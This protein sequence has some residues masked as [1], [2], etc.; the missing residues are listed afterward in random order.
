MNF[1]INEERWIRVSRP[2][3]G[4]FAS[5]VFQPDCQSDC[6]FVCQCVLWTDHPNT[7]ANPH[8]RR[9]ILALM[10]AQEKQLN[11][12]WIQYFA[13]LPR[14]VLLKAKILQITS[15]YMKRKGT[16]EEVISYQHTRKLFD[17]HLFRLHPPTEILTTVTYRERANNN[18]K[19]TR[20]TRR[21]STAKGATR[22][23]QRTFIFGY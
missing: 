14:K 2:V 8:T 20:T 18:E 5:T 19:P 23:T 7:E 22:K 13:K 11:L 4:F 16:T 1:K 17:I 12:K 15:N 10:V 6:L 3:G 21:T 9:A